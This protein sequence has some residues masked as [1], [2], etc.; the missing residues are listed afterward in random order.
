M[1]FGNLNRIVEGF[2]PEDPAA[3]IAAL[4]EAILVVDEIVRSAVIALKATTGANKLF[5]VERLA[6]FGSVA[7]APLEALLRDTDSQ[8]D[9]ILCSTL[10]LDIGCQAGVDCLLQ[11]VR[12]DDDYLCL[13][14]NKLARCGIRVAADA[15]VERLRQLSD[16]ECDSVN[17]LLIALHRLGS[18]V[19]PDLSR[20]FSSNSAAW[21]TRAVMAAIERG[22]QL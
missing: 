3:Q 17:C 15:I 7:R 10:L 4:D 16:L 11:T 21:Q 9:R 12:H 2:A 20:R 19:P 5:V 6:R 13:A 1:G 18:Q 22:D 8:E 14:A